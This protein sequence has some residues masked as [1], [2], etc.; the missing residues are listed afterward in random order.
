MV[1]LRRC[2]A[3]GGPAAAGPPPVLDGAGR[4]RA[5][6]PRDPRHAAAKPGRR[7]AAGGR[8]LA[9]RST[10]PRRAPGTSW[11][12]S[13]GRWRRTSARRASRSGICARRSLETH[14]LH[15]ALRE[16]GKRA[17][18]G[19]PVRFVTSVTGTPRQCSAKVENQLLRIGQE[20]ITNAVRHADAKRIHV[21]L[22]F[23]GRRRRAARLRRR[24]RIRS[25]SVRRPTPTG[26]TAW[27][28]C[29]SAPR[30]WAARVRRSHARD[31]AQGHRG[32]SR[33][34]RTASQARNPRPLPDR[35]KHTHDQPSHPRAL[36]RRS[37]HRARR[38]RR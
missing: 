3:H 35:P 33:T 20:A 30:S 23:D 26:I 29:G 13:A 11:C 16:F 32:R 12:E 2:G 24:T 38:H 22:R 27:R 37:P 31:R 36:R 34:C 18:A 19:K 15:A 14:D 4:T 28:R 17:T 9:T 25:A 1:G 7:R 8:H 6:E 21:E 5:L 10:R